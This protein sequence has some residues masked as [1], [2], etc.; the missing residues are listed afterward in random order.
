M[1]KLIPSLIA[2]L[3]SEKATLMITTEKAKVKDNNNHDI[4][5]FFLEYRQANE[6]QE[7]QERELAHL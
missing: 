3:V 6:Q 7:E 1:Q 2:Y 4:F 5:H